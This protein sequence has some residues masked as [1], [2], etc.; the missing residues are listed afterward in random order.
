M[1]TK[2]VL[3]GIFAIGLLVAN[4]TIGENPVNS[5]NVTLKNISLVQANAGEMYCDTE[6]EKEC[7]ITSSDGDVGK[8]TG[9]LV[10]VF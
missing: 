5:K 7:T 3:V 6:N 2:K 10:V 9:K 8:S 1:K 4:F